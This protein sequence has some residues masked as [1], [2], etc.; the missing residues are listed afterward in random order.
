[1]FIVILIIAI[2]APMGMD[3]MRIV[4]QRGEFTPEA[5]ALTTSLFV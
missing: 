5:A 3:I 1:L 4:Y 2:A